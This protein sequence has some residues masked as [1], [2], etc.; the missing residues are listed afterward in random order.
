MTEISEDL[1]VVVQKAKEEEIER[2]VYEK[3]KQDIRTL[4]FLGVGGLAIMASLLTFHSP[5]LRFVVDK[6]GDDL[7]TDIRTEMIQDYEKFK[8]HL[9][10]VEG[11]RDAINKETLS[12]LDIIVQSQ[13]AA[14]RMKSEFE[15]LVNNSKLDIEKI[16]EAHSDAVVAIEQLKKEITQIQA[17]SDNQNAI[18]A[19]LEAKGLSPDK[20]KLKSFVSSTSLPAPLAEQKGTVYFQFTGL[21]REVAIRIKEKIHE[22]GWTIPGVERTP[23]AQNTNEVRY[24]PSDKSKAELLKDDADKA[25]DDLNPIGLVLKE[26]SR[27][28]PGILE[29]WI[30]PRHRG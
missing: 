21:E 14:V 18:L 19:T 13:T 9:S 25:L 8:D 23:A 27:V 3:I 28:K 10:K 6:F 26:S 2:R 24:Y 5:I 17:L 4:K 20:G 7:R 1:L 12:H 22:S 16:T 29:I 11:I 15:D 30:D